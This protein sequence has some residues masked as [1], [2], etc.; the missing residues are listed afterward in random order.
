MLLTLQHW[1]DESI[2]QESVFMSISIHPFTEAELD[3]TDEVIKLAYKRPD[4]RKESL[5]RYLALQPDG[6]FVA[7]QND[8]VIGFGGALDYGPFAYIG[9]MCVHPSMQKRGIGAILLEQLHDWLDERGCPTFLLDASAA[10]APLYLQYSYI[11]DD[12]TAVF[13]RTQPALLPRHLPAG[14]SVLGGNDF[15][16]LVAYDTPYFGADRGAIL[17]TY[18]ADAPEHVLVVRNED[19]QMGGYLIAQPNSIGPWVANSV[20]DAERLLL[21]ALTLPFE[22]EPSVFVSAN[23]SDALGLLTSYGFSQQR[24]LSHMWKGKHVQRSRHTTIYGQAS[25]GFG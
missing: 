7:K 11:E 15:Q 3:A 19:G 8:A 20:E 23:N 9:L 1:I 4:S 14:V 21:H 6:S 2:P 17:A 18:R 5:R 25:L 10:G 13:K 24:V 16:A 12:I 22:S